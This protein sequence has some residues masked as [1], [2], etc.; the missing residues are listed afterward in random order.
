MKTNYLGIAFLAPP[1]NC[2]LYVWFI[3]KET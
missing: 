2:Y 3:E 1:T